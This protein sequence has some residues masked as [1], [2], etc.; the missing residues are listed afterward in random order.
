[1]PNTQALT[2]PR[3]TRDVGVAY[4]LCL[5]GLLGVAGLHR[6][7]TGRIGTGVL[8]FLTAGLCGLGTLV[9]LFLIPEQIRSYNE[10]VLLFNKLDSVNDR[11]Q[12]IN[13]TVGHINPAAPAIDLSAPQRTM[14]LEQPLGNRILN[15]ARQRDTRGFTVNDAVLELQQS[16]E[17]ICK[18]LESLMEK[19]CLQ[20]GNDMEGRVLYREV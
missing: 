20:V 3:G 7:Y 14:P 11:Q 13:V 6:F 18:E 5:C 1:M 17:N 2:Q 8:F 19:N 12:S 9:D 15:L 4:L 10:K 16:L